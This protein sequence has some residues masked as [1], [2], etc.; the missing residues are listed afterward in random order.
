MRS[1]VGGQGKDYQLSNYYWGSLFTEGKDLGTKLPCNATHYIFAKDE[2]TDSQRG[3][4]VSRTHDWEKAASGVCC[5]MDSQG[6]WA[7][8]TTDK[9]IRKKLKT[10][11]N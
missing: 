6:L 11:Y 7:S 9:Q 1:W 10:G 3:Y 4:L 8:H 5:V 2:Q